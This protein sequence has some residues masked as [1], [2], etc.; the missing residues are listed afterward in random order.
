MGYYRHYLVIS[1]LE[2]TVTS[3]VAIA[4][5]WKGVIRFKVC[6]HVLH[7]VGSFKQHLFGG[8]TDVSFN[9]VS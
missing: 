7:M 3:E 5:S 1:R 9:L 2:H 6:Y 4:S 8:S